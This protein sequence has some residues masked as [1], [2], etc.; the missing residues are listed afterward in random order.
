MSALR[1]GTRAAMAVW[2]ALALLLT[3]AATKGPLDV[4]VAAQ[5]R[6]GIRTEPL[7]A[8]GAPSPESR[9]ARVLDPEPLLQLEGELSAAE[10]SLAA[11]RAEAQRTQRLYEEDRT[12]SE[13]ALQA[14]QA[15]AATEGERVASV[16]RRLAI[17][18]GEAMARLPA[19]RRS[20]LMSAL[21]AGRSALVRVEFPWDATPPAAGEPVAIEARPADRAP[22]GRVLGALPL[23][24]P[25]LQT[26]GVLVELDGVRL[27]PVGAALSAH[28]RPA[29]QQGVLLPRPALLRHAGAVWCYVQVARERFERRAVRDYQPLA[30]GWFVAA[31]LAPGERVVVAGAESLLGLETAAPAAD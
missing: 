30:S 12:A 2:G 16:R 20:A 6:F 24:D 29:G 17:E 13:R 4:D 18:W 10:V 21:V 23:A 26:R 28:L 5:A 9:I 27:P 15:Q 31:G 8:R 14:A 22:E 19:A 1:V 25:R 11:A 3:W 7:Q